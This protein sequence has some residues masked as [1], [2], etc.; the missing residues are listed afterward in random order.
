MINLDMSKGVNAHYASDNNRLLE[1]PVQKE[2]RP[3]SY[4]SP[5][6]EDLSK[7]NKDKSSAAFRSVAVPSTMPHKSSKVQNLSQNITV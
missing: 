3:M 7:L 5:Q 6:M 4:K 1:T 2:T